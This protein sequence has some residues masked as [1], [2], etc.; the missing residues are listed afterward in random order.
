MIRKD[1]KVND[2]FYIVP[3]L[4]E[5]V[6]QHKKIGAYRVEPAQYR[7]LKSAAQV[8]AYESHGSRA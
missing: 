8:H 2:S 5:L 7:P 4:N 1:A 6:L 3:A